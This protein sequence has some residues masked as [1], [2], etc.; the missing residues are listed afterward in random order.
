[1]HLLLAT[2]TGGI[3]TLV[4]LGVSF[5]V[6]IWFMVLRPFFRRKIKQ[7]AENRTQAVLHGDE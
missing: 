4:M 3:I 5:L 6:I 1:M 7:A 2:N